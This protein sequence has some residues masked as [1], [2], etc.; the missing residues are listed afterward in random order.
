MIS[1]EWNGATSKI[2]ERIDE[3]FSFSVVNLNLF[4]ELG[5]FSAIVCVDYRCV[6][7]LMCSYVDFDSEIG[8]S[9]T[10]FLLND[11]SPR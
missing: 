8:S 10:H 1:G 6:V 5:F 3:T 11:F 7:A 2:I 4:L 9:E